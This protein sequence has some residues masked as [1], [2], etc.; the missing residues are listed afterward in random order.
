VLAQMA[1]TGAPWSHAPHWHSVGRAFERMLGGSTPETV[2]LLFA[3]AGV[4]TLLRPGAPVVSRAALATF[5]I[6]LGTFALA[7]AWSNVSSP[8]WA[9][10]YL[11]I[12][13]APAAIVIGAGLGRTGVVA[14]VVLAVVFVG[15]WYGKPAHSALAHKSNVAIIAHRLGPDLA[16][17]TQVFSTQ[18]EQ[19]PVLRYYLPDG[20]RYATPLGPVPDP[21]VMDWRDAMRR[22]DRPAA[23]W[24]FSRLLAGLRP[25]RQLLLVQPRFGSPSAPWTR[26]IRHLSHV[27]TRTL[28]ADR[29]IRIVARVIPHRGYNRST[30]SALVLERKGASPRGG[31]AAPP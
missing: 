29:G 20:L 26:R 7:Y 14:A 12:V 19:V 5:A 31:R 25:G 21:R 16:R 9:L 13:L 18:P 24:T 3:L 27:V 6:A 4:I 30:L 2:L 17:G 28:H 23:R 22:L 8:A 11:S 15:S 10:R 1:H